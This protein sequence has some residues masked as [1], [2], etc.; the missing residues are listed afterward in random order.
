MND[1]RAPSWPGNSRRQGEGGAPAH[2]PAYPPTRARAFRP[3]P[4][5]PKIASLKSIFKLWLRLQSCRARIPLIL[6]TNGGEKTA[7]EITRACGKGNAEDLP[8][9]RSPSGGQRCQIVANHFNEFVL[10]VL[11]LHSWSC[12]AVRGGGWIRT[13]ELM[14]NARP[15]SSPSVKHLT[16]GAS[17]AWQEC[18][19]T[20]SEEAAAAAWRSRTNS[21]A[22]N[23]TAEKIGRPKWPIHLKAPGATGV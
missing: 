23:I 21:N 22:R 12:R 20:A 8:A 5:R 16:C 14:L 3:A 11:A 19:A 13:C 4:Q 18:G 9:P 6:S 10:L 2:A 1:S 17:L 15:A 7:D